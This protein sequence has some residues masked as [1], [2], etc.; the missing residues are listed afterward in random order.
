MLQLKPACET[1]GKELPPESGD[2]RICSFECTFCVDCAEGKHQGTCPNCGG[3]FE[4]RP[5]RPAALLEK[6]PPASAETAE[7]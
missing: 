5:I 3:S 2:A 1:C 6:F 7:S 4:K